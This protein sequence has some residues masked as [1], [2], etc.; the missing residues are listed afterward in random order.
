[1]NSTLG[2]VVPL[3]MFSDCR[4][5]ARHMADSGQKTNTKYIN[6]KNKYKYNNYILHI[7]PTLTPER[8]FSDCRAPARHMADS[9]Q[10]RQTDDGLRVYTQHCR[11]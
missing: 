4:A 8:L 9:E 2:S 5:P 7:S 11:E 1:M 10:K 6:R 3:A